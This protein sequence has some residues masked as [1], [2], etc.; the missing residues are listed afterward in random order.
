MKV[1]WL[2]TAIVVLPNRFTLCTT[3]AIMQKELKRL[4]VPKAEWIDFNNPRWLACVFEVKD[5]NEDICSIV[6]IK[7]K[8]DRCQLTTMSLLV[9]EAVHV[10]QTGRQMLG[11]KN[12]SD[13]F[14]AYA[15]QFIS[16][17]LFKEYARQTA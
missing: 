7:V 3:D 12:P 2:D 1:K 15:L 6:L 5:C 10:W 17:S 9:H 14:E 13:E 8:P 16:Q 4:G 11:E